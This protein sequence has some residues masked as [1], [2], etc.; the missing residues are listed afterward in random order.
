MVAQVIVYTRRAG[1]TGRVTEGV[2]RFMALQFLRMGGYKDRA[3]A[4]KGA[5]THS[6]LGVRASI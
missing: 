4:S 5:R 6:L 3:G 2:R 1:L